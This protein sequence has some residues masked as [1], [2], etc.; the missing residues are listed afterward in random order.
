M[1]TI[2]LVEDE[3]NLN[4]LIKSY[5]ERENYEVVNFYNGEV[6]LFVLV[7]EKMRLIILI[8]KWI[9]GSLTLC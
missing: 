8:K 4:N 2:C 7:K 9:Y 3:V 6:R 5:L 1:Y